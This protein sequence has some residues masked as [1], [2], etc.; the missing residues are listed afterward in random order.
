MLSL[1]AIIASGS[2]AAFLEVT[3]ACAVYVLW[4]VIAG[5]V[6]RFRMA[7]ITL[8]LGLFTLTWILPNL[9]DWH[10]FWRFDFWRFNEVVYDVSGLEINTGR[11]V[12]W[13][14]VIAGIQERPLFGH[15]SGASVRFERSIGGGHT[16]KQSAHN[17][18]LTVTYQAGV[19]GLAGLVLY[20]QGIW[21]LYHRSRWS[22]H[23]RL[24]AAFFAAIA[25]RE[26]FEVSLTQN[27]LIVGVGAW[28]LI[29]GL[30]RLASVRTIQS[31]TR[32]TTGDLGSHSGGQ[33]HEHSPRVRRK[34]PR[35]SRN[36]VPQPMVC[37]RDTR[38]AGKILPSDFT[39]DLQIPPSSQAS[40]NGRRHP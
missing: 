16:L 38:A 40:I 36:A 12:L 29:G 9:S 39:R 28:T 21:M 35:T 26:A 5:S 31:Q 15:G 23:A 18:Y 2:R 30:L 32:G 13:P 33:S 20:L 10:R 24:G 17:L 19:V 14:H 1:L 8:V 11:E 3:L 34:N 22:A 4:P 25:L 7:F 6:A 37:R 27:N